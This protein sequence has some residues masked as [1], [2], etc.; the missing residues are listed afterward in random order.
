MSD[1]R[2]DKIFSY[3]QKL[4][5]RLERVEEN[6]STKDRLDHLISTMDDFIRRID[7]SET[8]Q[9][10]RDAQFERLLDWARKVPDKTGITLEGF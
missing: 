2:F 8:E 4:D 10:A 6:M 3:L 9:A 5:A 7:T 1:D